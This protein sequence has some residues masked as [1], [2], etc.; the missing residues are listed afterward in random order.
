MEQELVVVAF[1]GVFA[2]LLCLVF[3]SSIDNFREK[4]HGEAF[5]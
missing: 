1:A 2:F 4:S 3:C 5:H